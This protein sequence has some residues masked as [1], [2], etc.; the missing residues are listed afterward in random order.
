MKDNRINAFIACTALVAA[1]LMSLALS[2][3]IGKWS[4][5]ASSNT[6]I[7]KFPN[8]TGITPNS[9]VKFAGA[10]AGRVKEV[11]LIARKDQDQDPNT[12]LFNCVEVVTEVD[13]SLELG[14][15]VVATIKQDGFG[16]SAKYVLLT[17]GPDHDSP[18][19]ADNSVL[20]GEMPF[21]LSDLIQP[22]GEALTQAKILV[23]KLEPAMD[24][25]G[26]MLIHMESLSKRLDPILSHADKLMVDGDDV[27]GNFNTPD[28]RERLQDMI[29]NLSVATANLKVVSYNAKALTATLA[30]KPWRVFWGGSTIPAPSESDDLKSNKV[31][32]L[33]PDVE[34][35]PATPPASTASTQATN[36]KQ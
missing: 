8:A 36:A 17:P 11:R 2:F 30:S 19:L 12:R 32:H 33:K 15:D 22:A 9:E 16:I 26:P 28:S 4:F 31:I 1:V 18:P 3:A 5:G 13:K 23:A 35:N 21:D 6:F 29:A 14:S 25:L 24:Q 10:H 34:V 7:I 27:I 20:Q